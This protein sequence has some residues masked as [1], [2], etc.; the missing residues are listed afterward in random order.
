MLKL[1]IADDEANVREALARLVELYNPEM[2]IVASTESV[3]ATIAAIHDQQPDI[4]LLDIEMKEGTG[5]DVLRHFPSPRF[6][7]I[8]ITAYQHYAVQAFR[9]AALDYILKPADPEVLSQ[10]LKKAVDNIDRERLSVKIDSF[11][12]NMDSKQ[13]KKVVLKTAD[14]IHVISLQEIL[15]CEADRSYT[16]FYLADKSRIMVSNT[17]GQYEELFGDYGFLRI[18]QSYLLNVSYIRRY[19]KGDGGKII[20]SD[21]ISLP[22]ATR[23][24]DQLLQLLSRL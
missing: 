21:N 9:F 11:L 19:E 8:F 18:H 17:L 2:A 4:I 13:S 23:K 6:K 16:I 1:L 24:K 10:A 14:N 3:S 5:F 22:V 7:V 20:L 15:Y 12:N